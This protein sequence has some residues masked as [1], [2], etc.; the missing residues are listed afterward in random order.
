VMLLV[1]SPLLVIPDQLR[2]IL[3]QL[4]G[5]LAGL[6]PFCVGAVFTATP[7]YMLPASA[8]SR[9]SLSLA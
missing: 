4:R 8:S 3:G 7:V 2:D 6:A 9:A 5:E 1:V